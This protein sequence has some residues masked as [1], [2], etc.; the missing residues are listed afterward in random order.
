MQ[1]NLTMQGFKHFNYFAYAEFRVNTIS[2]AYSTGLLT[3]VHS[4]KKT[5]CGWDKWIK[6]SNFY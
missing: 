3:Y 5:I 6:I 1:K 2:N 4:S